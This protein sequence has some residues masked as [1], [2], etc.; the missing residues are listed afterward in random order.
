[1]AASLFQAFSPALTTLFGT[2]D[3]Q[4]K[5]GLAV[6]PGSSGSIARR[7]NQHGAEFYVRRYYGGDGTQ[8]D[9]YLGLVSESEKQMEA[10]AAQIAEVKATLAEIRLLLREGFQSVDSKTYAT[11]ASLHLHDLFAAGATLVG[12]HAFGAIANQMGVRAAAY[13][14]EDVDVARRET[15]AFQTIPK[16]NFLEMLRD[17]G[18]HFVAVPALDRRHA[19]SSFKQQGK[20]R[21][22]VDLLV[23]SNDDTI[24]V[25]AVP[26]LS[27][28]AT[29][30]P[31]L[32]YLLGQTQMTALLSREGCCPVRV[33]APERFAV[34]KLVVSQL[35][36]SREAKAGK[37]IFQ[38]GVILAALG[39]RFP[40]AIETAVGDLPASARKHVAKAMP[41]VLRILQN[42][43]RSADELRDAVTRGRKKMRK[44]RA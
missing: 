7:R 30:L 27:T 16:K 17:S 8:R 32:A 5:A 37:D 33:P 20:S 40:G 14:T 29:A 6:F 25:V 1:M 41:A 35:R 28:H 19:S 21:F 42:H 10:L 44:T 22:H 34:H 23:P 15:L 13:A 2:V 43:P 38:A 26:E 31:Y 9:D 4:A 11:L 3:G 36:T 39:D 18:I 12:S 24:R